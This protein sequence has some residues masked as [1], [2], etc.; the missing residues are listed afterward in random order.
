VET[1]PKDSGVDNMLD[2]FLSAVGSDVS[3]ILQALGTFLS[4]LQL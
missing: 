1:E 3:G 2:T 4:S